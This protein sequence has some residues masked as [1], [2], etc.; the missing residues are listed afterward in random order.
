MIG[1]DVFVDSTIEQAADN[2]TSAER[3][4]QTNFNTK[5][6][7]TY[8]SNRNRTVLDHIGRELEKRQRMD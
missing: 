8:H 4:V 6:L 1:A 2:T 3:H 5:I 7:R